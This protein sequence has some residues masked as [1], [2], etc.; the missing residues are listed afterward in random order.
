MQQTDKYKLNL[1]E[2]SDA[3][4]PDALNENTQKLEAALEEVTAH[5][6]A[7]DQAEAAARAA[8]AQ[9]VTALEARKVVVGSYTGDGSTAGQIIGLGFTPA[10]V[11]LGK[12]GK[13]LYLLTPE[14][15]GTYPMVPPYL[16]IVEGGFQVTY[17]QTSYA[18]GGWNTPNQKY[19]F[20][21]LL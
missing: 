9:R 3:F 4:S 21:A 1:V 10:A 12:D 6:D 11:L 16:Q 18:D 7:G 13:S 2:T 14:N 15:P 5:A 8:L 20:I 17:H 19:F